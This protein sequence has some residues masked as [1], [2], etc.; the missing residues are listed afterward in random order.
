V[1][2]DDLRAATATDAD[3]ASAAEARL[4]DAFPGTSEVTG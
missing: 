4:L 1:D 3:Q 2:P